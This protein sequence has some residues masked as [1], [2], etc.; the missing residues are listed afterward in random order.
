MDMMSE[1]DIDSDE[2]K[3]IE[4][5]DHL[6]QDDD[7][8][9]EGTGTGIE[10]EIVDDTPEEDRGRKPLN[11]NPE[12]SE[13][14]LEEYSEKVK[15]RIAK[16]R[17]GIHDE[18]R[19]KEAA[20]RER[21]EAVALAQRIIKEKQEVESIAKLG[22][23]AYVAQ[24]KERVNLAL[25][26]AK[27]EFKDAY[28]AGD[29]DALAAAQEKLSLLA[30]EK[31]QV[32]NL[33]RNQVASESKAE[34]SEK[35]ALQINSD[36]VK[37]EQLPSSQQPAVDEDALKWAKKNPWFRKDRVMTA[38]AFAIHDELMDMGI[39]PRFE[40]EEYYS[41]LD[42]RLRELFPSYK[43][44]DKAKAKAKTTQHTPVA[45][46]SRTTKAAKRVVLTKTQV[47]LA[48]RLGLTP[49]QY[50]AEVNALANKEN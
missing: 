47:S 44:E 1:K 36:D 46:V 33:A 17:H 37:H 50:A 20:Q 14:E 25:A 13:E 28:E 11:E 12:P 16:M 31:I 26:A 24:A 29:S 40:S 3:P 10:V 45:A 32:E 4:A 38:A 34:E 35:N 42:R 8:L 6:P 48:R 43:W 7:T 30:V 15:A 18:R 23:S 21:D 19:A 49:E 22:E 41:S 5:D 2:K 39:D 9:D 27:K